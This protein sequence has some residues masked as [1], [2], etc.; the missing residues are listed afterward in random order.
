MNAHN[1][2]TQ[3]QGTGR[4]CRSLGWRSDGD[5]NEGGPTPGRLVSWIPS[6]LLGLSGSN[7]GDIDQSS[8]TPL[9]ELVDT[10][11]AVSGC[12]TLVDSTSVTIPFI[13]QLELRDVASPKGISL[14]RCGSRNSLS[15]LLKRDLY[16]NI[17]FVS[18][19]KALPVFS[20]AG[21]CV[22][23]TKRDPLHCWRWDVRTRLK[24]IQMSVNP[25]RK[26]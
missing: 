1:T 15:M 21:K 16:H 6:R 9:G 12:F 19:G 8:P 2:G 3:Q 13:F 25:P 22:E 14:C 20:S 24:I 17:I 11:L 18:F 7:L 4:G 5:M 10:T 26:K 23:I